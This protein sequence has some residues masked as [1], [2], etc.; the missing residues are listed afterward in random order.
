M[1][2]KNKI[3]SQ[4]LK[5]INKLNPDAF[6]QAYDL[7]SENIYR[8][9]YW[10]TS[11]KAIAEDLT[12]QTF[13]K[14]WEHLRNEKIIEHWSSFV[15]KVA[16]NLLVDYYRTNKDLLDETILNNIP[17]EKNNKENINSVID[18]DLDRQKL[19]KHINKLP[20]DYQDIIKLRYIDDLS[21]KEISNITG[22]NMN[23]LYVTLHRAIKQ[24]KQLCI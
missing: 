21:F 23:S 10:R 14:I 15:Y 9:F 5:E 3:N 11:S 1:K 12:S 6:S 18:N 22:K 8:F 7:F 19:L 13:L 16:H 20:E 17:D 2:G 24:L 4:L